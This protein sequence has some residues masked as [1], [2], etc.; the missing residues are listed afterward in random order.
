MTPNKQIQINKSRKGEIIKEGILQEKGVSL[1]GVLG[2][3]SILDQQFIMD[4]IKIIVTL[5]GGQVEVEV[6]DVVEVEED[7]EVEVEG[8]DVVE[9]VEED[10]EV[11]EVEAF[12]D[13]CMV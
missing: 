11:E 13:S 3:E 9:A 4:I 6:V 7:V 12:E 8:V 5:T 2:E 1:L 10:V